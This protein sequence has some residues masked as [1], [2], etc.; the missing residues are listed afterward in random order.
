VQVKKKVEKVF[1][2]YLAKIGRLVDIYVRVA[3]DFKIE[4]YSLS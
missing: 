3:A 1:S 2:I 4:I